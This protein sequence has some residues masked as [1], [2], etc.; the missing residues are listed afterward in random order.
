MGVTCHKWK[1]LLLVRVGCSYQTSSS[2]QYNY[3]I[4]HNLSFRCMI[5]I[6]GE[7]CNFVFCLFSLCPGYQSRWPAKT[8]SQMHNKVGYSHY[9]Y[10]SKAHQQWPY[11]IQLKCTKT[12]QSTISISRTAYV[13]AFHLTGR[14]EKLALLDID[15][16]P[17]HSHS[18]NNN[19]S[20]ALAF[21]W[22]SGKQHYL[23]R[24]KS[25]HNNPNVWNILPSILYIAIVNTVVIKYMP[26]GS[27]QQKK[28]D[29]STYVDDGG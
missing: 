22:I 24:R 16:P 19:T 6:R 25:C 11:L 17:P 28:R 14:L 23:H 9:I 8:H 13:T 29:S 2:I 12:D 26:W 7:I 1:L 10:L 15:R 21:G 27:S 3:I 5:L 18:N 20:D 4:V